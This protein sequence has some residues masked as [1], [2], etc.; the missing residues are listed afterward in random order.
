VARSLRRHA[1]PDPLRRWGSG[2]EAVV[3]EIHYGRHA[4]LHHA[5]NAANV[6]SR[7]ESLCKTYTCEA[8]SPTMSA[9]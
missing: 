1:L 3:G 7:L 2:R 6:A 5:R 4:R 8:V 9:H